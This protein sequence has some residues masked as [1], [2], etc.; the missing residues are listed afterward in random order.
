MW[1]S[2]IC[3]EAKEFAIVVR[4][5]LEK[6]NYVFV[7]DMTSKTYSRFVVMIPMMG[8][9]HVFRYTVEYPSRFIIQ[10]Y[11]TYPSTKP[12]LMPFMEIDPITEGNTKDI[13]QFLQEI[14]TRLDRPPWE[15]TKGQRILV[16][17]YLPEFRKARKAWAEFGFDTSKRATKE[18]KRAEK[19]RIRR[20]KSGTPE[21]M[22]ENGKEIS[23]KRE[24]ES[25]DSA[26]EPE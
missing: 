7:R 15:F 18:R 11:D 23:G 22:L 25:K 1:S 10:L 12:G 5:S 14:V 13:K 8:G 26:G 19:S 16:G 3:Y 6:L 17:Y 9:A 20:E 21:E 24:E 4:E 2:P